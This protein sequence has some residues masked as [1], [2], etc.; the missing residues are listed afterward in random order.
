MAK[1]PLEWPALEIVN[2][3]FKFSKDLKTMILMGVGPVVVFTSS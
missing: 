3:G 1:K 2:A